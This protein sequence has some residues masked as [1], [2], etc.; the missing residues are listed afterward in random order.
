MTNETQEIDADALRARLAEMAQRARDEMAG[1]SEV[2]H[3]DA[4][5]ARQHAILTGVA[6]ALRGDPGPLASHSHHDLAERAAAMVA[7]LAA[8]RAALREYAPRCCDCDALPTRQREG[9][10]G[11]GGLRCD[12]CAASRD[13]VVTHELEHAAALRAATVTP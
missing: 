3:L 5:L 9:Y 8:A 4:L 7:L 12:D 2:D 6:N 11:W 13:L 10:E 1:A